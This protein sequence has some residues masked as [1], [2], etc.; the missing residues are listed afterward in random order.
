[1]D[2]FLEYFYALFKDLINI[3]YFLLY[4][5]PFT[6][7]KPAHIFKHI[8]LF[9]NFSIWSSFTVYLLA[10]LIT[11]AFKLLN[12]VAKTSTLAFKVGCLCLLLRFLKVKPKIGQLEVWDG[13]QLGMLGWE[14]HSVPQLCNTTGLLMLYELLG[15][16]PGTPASS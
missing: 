4:L 1:M 9:G 14:L 11:W 3:N 7:I 16:I 5:C 15:C 2:Y 8:N 10:F 6:F 13:E 12:S